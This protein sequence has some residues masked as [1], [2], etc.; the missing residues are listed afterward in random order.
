VICDEDH[1]LNNEPIYL[2]FIGHEERGHYMP[3]FKKQ[4]VE[5]ISQKQNAI[6]EVRESNNYEELFD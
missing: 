4:K 2:F 1:W 5:E 6:G 3:L